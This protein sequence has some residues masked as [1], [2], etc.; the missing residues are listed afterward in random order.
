MKNKKS[1]TAYCD[2]IDPFDKLTDQEAGQL[3]KH[4]FQ[5]VNDQDPEPPSRLIDILFSPIKST[6][7]R[8]LEKWKKVCE[9]NKINGMKGGRN[10]K[11]T[12]PKNPNKP[13]G[14]NINPKNP[15][16]PDSDRDS[17]S[18][19]DRD[20]DSDIDSER[21]IKKYDD[22]IYKSIKT[23][24]E[25][26]KKLEIVHE[27]LVKNK[28]IDCDSTKKVLKKLDE[29]QL[30]LE[31]SGDTLKTFKDYKTHFLNWLKKQKEKNSDKKEK[32]YLKMEDLIIPKQIQ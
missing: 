10:A 7:K 15:N 11:K 31:G 19:R 1:F 3:I 6:L 27:A 4:I 24:Y 16:E 2:W 5:Y 14:L 29:F 28:Y 13:N 18:D 22:E 25:E 8:D 32:D 21:V 20:R 26:Y 12:N 17:D 30:N 9:K 23:H